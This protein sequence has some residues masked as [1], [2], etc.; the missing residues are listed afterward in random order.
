MRLA[1]SSEAKGRSRHVTGTRGATIAREV[2]WLRRLAVIGL[3]LVAAGGGWW[4][5]QRIPHPTPL[6]R[7]TPAQAET[8]RWNDLGA[9]LEGCQRGAPQGGREWCAFSRG[10]WLSPTPAPKEGRS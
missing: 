10:W 3:V 2:A 6:G 9:L 5:G 4:A 8:L 7:L 1:R